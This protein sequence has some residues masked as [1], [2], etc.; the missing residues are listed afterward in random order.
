MILAALA[1]SLTEVM[2]LP[3]FE[4][5]LN[6]ERAAV[7]TLGFCL[8]DRHALRKAAYQ[9]SG[10]LFLTALITPAYL[11][12]R[13][14]RLKKRPTYAITWICTFMVAGLLIASI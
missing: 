3:G 12:V 2:P 5:A 1:Q 10:W 8:R 9:M 6:F 4:R 13:A 14:K 11:F 7:I